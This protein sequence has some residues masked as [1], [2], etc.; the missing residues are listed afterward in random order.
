MACAERVGLR[1]AVAHLWLCPGPALAA[2]APR[3]L[4]A[5]HPSEHTDRHD[6]AL[7]RAALRAVLARYLGCAPSEVEI[8]RRCPECGG[9]HGPPRVP[10]L[11]ASISYTDGLVAIAVADRPVG[12]DVELVRPDFEWEPVARAVLPDAADLACARG[13]FA[14]WTAHEAL[15]KA[16]GTGLTL[17]GEALL[18]AAPGTTA[19]ANWRW[20]NRHVGALA[21]I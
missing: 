8:S 12:V 16:L 20:G 9:D 6:R 5:L 21:V 10:G 19:T 15:G 3:F 4:A 11:H 2:Q 13:F 7:G 14:A 17:D 1:S 18:R